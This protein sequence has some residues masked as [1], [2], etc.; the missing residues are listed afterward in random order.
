[1][2][3]CAIQILHSACFIIS[4]DRF[5]INATTANHCNGCIIT[6]VLISYCSRCKWYKVAWIN[7]LN[8]SSLYYTS[9][10]SCPIKR[11]RLYHVSMTFIVKS[12]LSSSYLAAGDSIRETHA[13]MATCNNK[14]GECYCASNGRQGRKLFML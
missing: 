14:G 13:C 3:K 10:S 1:M 8:F 12:L 5:I 11:P 4:F 2:N 9:N 7:S 6:F